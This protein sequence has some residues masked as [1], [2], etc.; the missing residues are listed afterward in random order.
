MFEV[1]SL[2][3]ETLGAGQTS[4]LPLSSGQ[5]LPIAWVNVYVMSIK[6]HSEDGKGLLL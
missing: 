6:G 5:W 4:L 1:D 2:T 3:L